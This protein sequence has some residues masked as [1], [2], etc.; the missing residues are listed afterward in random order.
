MAQPILLDVPVRDPRIELQT[1]LENAPLEHAEA[2]LSAYEVLQGLH[3]RGVLDLMRGALGSS[4][5]VL[6]IFVNAMNTPGSVRGIRN[7][8]VL[9]TIL[10]EVEPELVESFARSLPEAIA[11]TK[12]HEAKPPGFWTILKQFGSRDFRRGLVLVNSLLEAFGRNLPHEQPGRDKD[13]SDLKNR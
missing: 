9:A 8:I 6:E 10:G 13:S 1:R 11:V 3:D 2:L 12:A 4:D 7:A 5:K